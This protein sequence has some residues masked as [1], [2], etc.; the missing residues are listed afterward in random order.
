LKIAPVL[1]YCTLLIVCPPRVVY[2][3]DT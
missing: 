3:L 2:A 1:L